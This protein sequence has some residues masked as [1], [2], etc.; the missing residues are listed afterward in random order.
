LMGHDDAGQ[1]AQE[2]SLEEDQSAG[3]RK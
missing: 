3:A 2:D 1:P